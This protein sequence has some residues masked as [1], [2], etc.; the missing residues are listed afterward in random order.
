MHPTGHNPHPI[1]G[2]TDRGSGL[3]MMVRTDGNHYQLDA[4]RSQQPLYAV[5]EQRLSQ[6]RH[7]GLGCPGG[8]PHTLPGSRH[9]CRDP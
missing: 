2:I 5:P 6:Q 4:T 1:A 9:H 3:V 8:Q 7:K